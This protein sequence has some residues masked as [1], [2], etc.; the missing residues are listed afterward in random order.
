MGES[1]GPGQLQPS[2]GSLAMQTAAGAGGWEGVSF[3][4]W[5]S[6]SLCAFWRKSKQSPEDLLA[7]TYS[8]RAPPDLE[9]PAS[10]V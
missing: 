5:A 8:C 9:L 6:V 3:P 4:L 1:M 7:L 10:E 2:R